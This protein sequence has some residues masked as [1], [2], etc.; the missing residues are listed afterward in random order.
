MA[1]PNHKPSDA[2]RAEATAYAMVGVPHHDI[3]IL[4]GLTTKTL[5]KHYR[6]ELDLGKA[7]ANAQIGGKLFKKASGGD[8]ACMI[9]WMKAQAG[10]REVQVHALTDPDGKA[11]GTALHKLGPT[12][13]P[14]QA[15]RVYSEMCALPPPSSKTVQ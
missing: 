5:L 4:L 14:E 11:L 1:R 2:Q 13:T 10:W 6:R 3:S 12:A 15:E 8:T 7:R 9:F